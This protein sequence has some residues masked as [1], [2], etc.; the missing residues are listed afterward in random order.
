M[1]RSHEYA[2]QS[3]ET[4]LVNAILD[5]AA[6][7]GAPREQADEGTGVS[8]RPRDRVPDLWSDRSQEHAGHAGCDGLWWRISRQARFLVR[9]NLRIP[10]G[11][12]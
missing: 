8:P 5:A 12:P 1:A 9:S 11:R 3:E 2:W 10:H 6:W 7:Q 4:E